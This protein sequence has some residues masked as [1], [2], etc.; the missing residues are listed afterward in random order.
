MHLKERKKIHCTKQ[1]GN[2][3][4]FLLGATKEK[5]G[6]ENILQNIKLSWDFGYRRTRTSSLSKGKIQVINKI[7]ENSVYLGLDF[8]FEETLF[9]VHRLKMFKIV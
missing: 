3:A 2:T 9:H 5:G 4:Y 6:I 1:Q 7:P 8:V